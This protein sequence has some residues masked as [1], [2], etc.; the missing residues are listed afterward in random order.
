MKKS[1]LKMLAGLALVVSTSSLA[2]ATTIDFDTLPDGSML[3]EHSV[4]TNQYATWGVTFSGVENGQAVPTYVDTYWGTSPAGGNYWSNGLPDNQDNWGPERRDSLI[5]SFSTLASGIGFDFF[6]SQGGS[7]VT[8]NFYGAGSN[9]LGTEQITT[10]NWETVS[11]PYEDVSYLE[12]L[13]PY[14]TW[15]F[16]MDNLNYTS[17]AAVPEPSTFIL[18]GAGLAGAALLRRRNRKA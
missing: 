17:A 11:F 7:A 9:L 10:M 15:F 16:N 4:L 18:F 12:L 3:A 5:I 2:Q 8:A 6:N 14:D 13:Q 1:V